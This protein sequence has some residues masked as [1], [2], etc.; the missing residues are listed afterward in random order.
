MSIKLIPINSR[1]RQFLFIAL[2]FPFFMGGTVSGETD[3][4]RPVDVLSSELPDSTSVSEEETE[5]EENSQDEDGE[6][7]WYQRLEFSGDFRSRYEGFYQD[8]RRG[9]NRQRGRLRLR[10]RLDTQIN[11][12]ARFQVRVTS[13]DS[14]TPVSTNQTF[15]SFFRPKPFNL[16][17][18]FLSYNPEKAS[19]VTLGMGKFG[20][21]HQRTQL[22]FDDDL[23][24]EG[25][26]EQVSWSLSSGVNVNLI[27]MQAVVNEVSRGEDSYMLMGY[28]EVGFSGERSEFQISFAN[29]RW[30]NPDALVM[31]HLDGPLSAILTNSL[32]KNVQGQVV[33]YASEFNVVDVISEATIQTS[34][35]GYPIRFLAEFARN[36]RAVNGRDS[37][38]WFE[39]EY[40]S[41]RAAHTWGAAYTY[42][43]LEQDLTPSAYVFSDIAGTNIRL[44][45]IETSYVPKEGL[46]FD[47][48]LHLTK[49]LVVPEGNP[50]NLLGRL[51]VAVVASF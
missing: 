6:T 34:R 2:I 7:P 1:L 15:T 31:G 29:N 27:A 14:G 47:V 26:W 37:G 8:G 11:D 9:G 42:G 5:A 28:G 24:F 20:A 46:S 3:E 51:H 21:P 35:P 39:A 22:M 40:G 12:D 4:V 50:N 19:A 18:A 13:G 32:A 16:D 33:G 49:R 30:T 25:G 44:H 45:M 43:W 38:W 48:T 41:P 10:L 17:R 36:T 23:N